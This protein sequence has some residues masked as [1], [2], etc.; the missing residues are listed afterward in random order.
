MAITKAFPA[1]TLLSGV[2][3]N[4]RLRPVGED[5]AAILRADIAGTGAVTATINVYVRLTNAGFA[6]RSCSYDLSLNGTTETD[7]GGVLVAKAAFVGGPDRD[8]R[9]GAAVTVNVGEQGVASWVLSRSTRRSAAFRRS[10]LRNRTIANS[11]TPAWDLNV[12]NIVAINTGANATVT[13]GAPSNV[14]QAGTL[15]MVTVTGTRQVVARSRGTRRTSSD[16]V[17][18]YQQHGQQEDDRGVHQRWNGIGGR[19]GGE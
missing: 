16:G 19:W 7:K 3:S 4:L 5:G 8:Q 12:G 13:F 17:L 18:E 14:P 9:H 11:A 1:T 2:T 10:Y 6:R 15:C